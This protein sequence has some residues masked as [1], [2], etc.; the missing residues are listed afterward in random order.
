MAESYE[1]VRVGW[2]CAKVKGHTE[3]KIE[4]PR[5]KTS[6]YHVPQLHHSHPKSVSADVHLHQFL[7][8]RLKS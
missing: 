7:K 8:K 4:N 3:L 5:V 6:S 1:R 2:H